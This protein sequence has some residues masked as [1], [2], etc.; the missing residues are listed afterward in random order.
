M[1]GAALPCPEPAAHARPAARAQ[2]AHEAGTREAAACEFHLVTD[3]AGFDALE[4]EWDALFERSGHDTQVFQTFAWAWHW[5]NH[6]LSRTC[7]GVHGP[8]LAVV[9]AR[10]AGRLV[11]VWPLVSEQASGLRQLAWMGEPV[12]QYGDVLVED[13]AD[14]A[15]ILRGAWDFL[16]AR[17]TP[18]LVRFRKVRADAAIAPLLAELGALSTQHQQAPYLDL[19]SAQ[20]F[21]AYEERYSARWRRNRRRLAR[22]FAERGE[23]DFERCTGGTR[24]RELAE[25]AITLKRAWLKERGLVSLALHNP[26]T[27]GFFADVAEGLTRPTGCQVSA[28]TCGGEAA[29]IEI[30]FRCKSRIV[31]H[32]I[33][34]NLKYE[35]AGAGALVLEDTIAR[36]CD[37]GRRTFDLLAPADAYKLD[38][39]DDSVGVDDW[40][41]PLT[42]KG[43]AYARLYL[44]LARSAAKWLIGILPLALRRKLSQRLA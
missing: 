37:S 43:R 12:S 40:A 29:A 28:L 13:G 31:M 25:I 38:W 34:F 8:T 15:S 9:T 36:A 32:I 22:R 11:M 3:R 10:R 44:G 35:S 19:G 7:D 1:L 5:C 16:V 26:R 42:F 20:S 30:T 27:A 14:T 23:T 21:A 4:Q 33:V 17:L 24:A 39:A 6:Y 2:D 41:L 18:D